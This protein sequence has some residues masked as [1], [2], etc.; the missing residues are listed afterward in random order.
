MEKIR[1]EKQC[2]NQLCCEHVV[3]TLTMMYPEI[4]G[5]INSPDITDD[6]DEPFVYSRASFD[7]NLAIDLSGW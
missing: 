3:K 1:K 5:L 2:P 4:A 7:E 6:P